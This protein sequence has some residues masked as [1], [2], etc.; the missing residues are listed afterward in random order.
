MG[1]FGRHDFNRSEGLPRAG[2][3]IP[4]H[5]GDGGGV[6]WGCSAVAA[7]AAAVVS[8]GEGSYEEIFENT[9]YSCLGTPPKI[10]ERVFLG[11]SEAPQAARRDRKAWIFKKT[12]FG[13]VPKRRRQLG[14][15]GKLVFP[16]IS[17][18]D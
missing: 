17:L 5:V 15:T 16:Q 1:C 3:F 18:F 12:P 11:G 8:G 14:G 10:Q 2:Y 6:G 4:A 9:S 13:G 7:V